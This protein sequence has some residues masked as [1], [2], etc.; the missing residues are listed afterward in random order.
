MNMKMRANQSATAAEMGKYH[1][2]AE[3]ARGG[4][5]N[6]YLAALCGPAGFNK[7][8]ALKD[9]KPEFSDDET[10]VAMFLE[11]ARLA[12]RLIHPNIVQTN[13]ISSEESRHYIVMEYLDGRSLARVVRRFSH[14]AGFPVG[15]QVRILC[16]ALLGLHYAHELRGF[17]GEHLGIV[18]R[19]VSPLNLM[20]TFD[21]QAKVLDFGI[22][23]S[24]D[25]SLETKA[26]VL[27][28]RAAYM[29]PEQACSG[30]VDRRADIYGVGVMLWEAAAG[31]R[32]WP[33]LS[34]VEILSRLLR[35]E[36]PSL[37]SVAAGAPK[38]LETICVRAMA[39]DC[40]NRYATAAEMLAD[41]EEHLEHRDDAMTMR[42]IGELVGQAFADERRRMNEIIEEA[43][44]RLSGG[45][46]S[47]VMPTFRARVPNTPSSAWLL[48]GEADSI[49]A[50]QY[51]APSVSYASAILHSGPATST[52]RSA[53]TRVE[54]NRNYLTKRTAMAAS[55]VGAMV[56]LGVALTAAHRV[57]SRQDPVESATMVH[58]AVASTLVQPQL[59]DPA[60]A[61]SSLSQV[62][63]VS[64]GRGGPPPIPTPVRATR[65]TAPTTPSASASAAPA[66]ITGSATRGDSPGRAPLRPIVTSSPY[67]SL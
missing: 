3:L 37:R 61:S 46:R 2:V 54:Q 10:Y 21:G 43:L 51:L 16:E 12:A 55:A 29:A 58:S 57:G 30:K 26:G 14:D 32:L 53:A 20:V 34:E 60:P 48:R 59:V 50:P 35:E 47:G 38:E 28:G 42:Q 23:K 4:M 36:P 63:S 24:V 5:G 31:R 67:G 27:K 66:A 9:L 19:D 15:A 1:L 64:A 18:H 44:T 65:R 40:N 13:E 22:A 41:L 25:S 49:S 45:A 62:T 7:L 52:F 8:L 33:G 6:V 17:D 56:V 39:K 11:E